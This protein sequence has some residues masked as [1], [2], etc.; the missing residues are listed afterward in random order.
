MMIV[1]AY[2]LLGAVAGLIAGVFGLGGG[3]VIVPT[4]IFTFTYLEF[5]PAI[6]THL[7]IG[8]SLTTI[9]FTSLS[10]IYVHHK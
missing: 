2:L 9:L 10:A 6:L 1:T 3:I 4:L 8:T 7:A 5:A